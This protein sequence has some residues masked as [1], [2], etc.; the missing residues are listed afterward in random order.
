[1]PARYLASVFVLAAI[2]AAVPAGTSAQS[3]DSLKAARD[4]ARRDLVKAQAAFD[5]ADEA[6]IQA[7]AASR[8]SSP[9]PVPSTAPG[10]QSPATPSQ[11]SV[12]LEV[13]FTMNAPGGMDVS[14][15][16]YRARLIADEQ[17]LDWTQHASGSK[18][19]APVGT[20][21]LAYEVQRDARSDPNS[22]AWNTVC[23]GTLPLKQR[24][25]VE[26]AAGR[27]ARCTT[28]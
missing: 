25:I 19:I 26:I 27:D 2:I 12:P 11:A 28:R 6:Y 4:Q 7:L 15:F 24:T 10:S 5:R 18:Q 8:A 9:E 22:P 23:R 21:L 3:L 17:P 20:R 14:P 1:M 13:T 16:D